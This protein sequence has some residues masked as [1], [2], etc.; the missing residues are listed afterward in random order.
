MGGAG[1]A[2]PDPLMRSCSLHTGRTVSCLRTV[3][4]GLARA[5]RDATGATRL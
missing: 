2:P 1:T 4:R 3:A 5:G